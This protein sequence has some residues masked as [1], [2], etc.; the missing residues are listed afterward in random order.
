MPHQSR[1]PVMVSSERV[2]YE[3]SPDNPP[4]CRVNPGDTVVFETIDA[5]GGQIQ[6]E[7]DLFEKVGWDR[8]NP[9]T[10]PVLVEGAE[11]GDTLAVEIHSIRVNSPGIMVAVPGLGAIPDKMGKAKTFVVPISNGLAHLPGDILLETEPMIGVIGTAPHKE[12]IP[13]GTPGL[14]GGNMDTTVIAEGATVYL[15]VLVPGGLLAMGDLH[16]LMGDGE[17]LVSGVEVGGKVTVK[18]RLVREKVL[19][20]PLVETEEAFYVI[21]SDKTL[22]SAAYEVTWRSA[23]LLSRHLGLDF[24]ESVLLLSA[25]GNLQISQVVDPLKTVRMEIPKVLLKGRSLV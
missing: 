13:C 5:F 17:V 8:V 3:F 4:C 25:K 7:Q 19:P 15:P 22:D 6:C 1:N 9:A 10:G 16:A 12:P 14:H 18:V 23:D 24:D 11:P 21:W 20:C 2:I